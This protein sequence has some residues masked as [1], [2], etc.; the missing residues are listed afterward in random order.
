MGLGGLGHMDVKFGKAFLMKVT[1]FSTSSSKEKAVGELL[2]ADN[3]N[4]SKN[5]KQMKLPSKSTP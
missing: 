5:P 1:I 4:V 3:F 2:G